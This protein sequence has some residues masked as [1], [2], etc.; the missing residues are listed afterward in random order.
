[1]AEFLVKAYGEKGV[2][3]NQLVL[4]EQS[5]LEGIRGEE[6]SYGEA[7]DE[8]VANAFNRM[9]EDGKVMDRIAEIRQVDKSLGD[10]IIECIRN[11]IKRFQIGR[12]SC[13]ERV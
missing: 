4:K 6:V 9:L 8:V 11:F 5:R 12:A 3:M 2:S 1:M 13:R 7:Y 10:K